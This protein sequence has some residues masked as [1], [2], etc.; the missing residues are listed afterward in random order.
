L[1]QAIYSIVAH[2]IAHQW[3]GN[4]VTMAWWDNLWLNEAFASWMATKT[5]AKFHPQWRPELRRAGHLEYAM[6]EDA[7]KTTHPVQ[8]AVEDDSRAMDIFDAITYTK[9]EAFIYMLE[10]YLGENVF[11]D[12]VRQYMRAHRFS[13]TT[14]ADLWH[15]L[16]QASG[17]DVRSFA[18]QWTEQPGFPLV[19]VAHRCEGGQALVTLSQQRFTLNDPQA[20]PL[21]WNVPVTLARG[22]EQ[23]TIVL[24]DGP[25]ELRFARLRG[26][27]RRRG[28]LLP[29]AVRRCRVQPARRDT[30]PAGCVRAAA[31]AGGHVRV[32]AGR[33][34]G[35]NALTCA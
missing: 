25:T 27:A 22:S 13:N 1:Q 12:G 29:G 18:A 7:R 4:L 24:S 11:R 10:G 20:A 9:G 2:E 35:R 23:R 16:A 19:R 21:A 5:A 8:T 34:R 28:R 30:R 31:A 14:T 26:G 6:A 32:R 17:R 15:H 3:F 33:K